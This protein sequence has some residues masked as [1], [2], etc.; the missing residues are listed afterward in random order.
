LRHLSVSTGSLLRPLWRPER[1]S[2]STRPPNFKKNCKISD[3]HKLTQIKSPKS[4][5]GHKFKVSYAYW[6]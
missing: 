3:I 1:S 2:A 4:A 5:C 6:V